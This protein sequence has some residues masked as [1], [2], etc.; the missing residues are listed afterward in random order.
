MKRV[1][2]FLMVCFPLFA[3]GQDCFLSRIAEAEKLCSQRKYKE[4]EEQ[5]ERAKKC[6]DKPS[7]WVK[8][9]EEK[10]RKCERKDNPPPPPPTQPIPPPIPQIKLQFTTDYNCDL[11]VDGKEIGYMIKGPI[12]E[13]VLNLKDTF[14]INAYARE[15][16]AEYQVKIA[17]TDIKEGEY[18]P[19]KL[20]EKVDSIMQK[21]R[22]KVVILSVTPSKVYFNHLGGTGIIKVDV[23]PVMPWDTLHFPEYCTIVSKHLSF[24]EIKCNPNPDA[25]QRTD[26]LKIKAG[27]SKEVRVDIEQEAA[28]VALS[29]FPKN[30]V[31]EDTGGEEVINV[32]TNFKK[33]EVKM[34]DTV[35]WASVLR[36]GSELVKIIC[37]D[38][39]SV[40]PRK[41]AYTIT[42]DSKEDTITIEQKSKP[43]VLDVFPQSLSFKHKGGTEQV[44]VRTATGEYEINQLNLWLITTKNDAGFSV[45]CKPYAKEDLQA[46][47]V[48]RTNERSL[49]RYATIEINVMD[50]IREI[51]VK[52]RAYPTAL[53]I[54]YNIFGLSAA[55]MQKDWFYQIP[56][57]DTTAD[58][59]YVSW[60]N[61]NKTNGVQAGFRIDPYFNSSLFGL[62]ISTG[63][64]YQYAA[65]S[66]TKHDDNE[67]K[68]KKSI[69]EH[70][71][72]LPIHLIYRYDFTKTVGIFINGGLGIDC[73]LALSVNAKSADS[74][75]P[76]DSKNIYESTNSKIGKRFVFTGEYGGGIK[77][78]R[79]IFAITS[80]LKLFKQT[81][82]TD[83]FSITPNSN[84]KIAFAVMLD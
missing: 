30:I 63:L 5:F 22:E 18:I 54:P 60:E 27:N 20:S 48:K 51:A 21:E 76:Y 52:Q 74:D 49:T 40:S 79:C 33:W 36:N 77:V 28:P 23:T 41:A 47:R 55:Y 8:I 83:T 71:L 62:G 45:K 9:L 10:V 6:P 2:I 70:S 42:A 72:Y 31:F 26:W 61:P 37:Q 46:T 25:E 1:V 58:Y 24:L 82:K 59:D 84:L 68:Y 78:S 80:S 3:L 15:V 35:K 56:I 64:Y 44:Q 67:K 7:D 57:K 29:I 50:T 17:S 38:N 19:I 81:A 4:A 53:K 11:Y 66:F 43:I 73:S 39:P 13:I 16:Y 34:L 14:L 12:K 65:K 32:E 69:A 75:I